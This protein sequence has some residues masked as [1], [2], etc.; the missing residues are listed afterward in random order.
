M[1]VIAIDPAP[2]K[3]STMYS[4]KDGFQQ[5]P[6]EKMRSTLQGL[7]LS[8]LICWKETTLFLNSGE[9]KERKCGSLEGH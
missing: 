8:V 9:P 6:G 1:R 3:E 5:I 4:A 7:K 2:R